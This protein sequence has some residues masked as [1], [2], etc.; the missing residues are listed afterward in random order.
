MVDTNNGWSN[1]VMGRV[2][3][4]YATCFVDLADMLRTGGR[5]LQEADELDRMAVQIEFMAATMRRA[6][7][8]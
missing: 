3:S 5:W 6:A 8:S 1:V 4:S 7:G 2:L